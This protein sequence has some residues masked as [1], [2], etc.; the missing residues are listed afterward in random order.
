MVDLDYFK[1]YNDFHGHV[2]GD[3]LL[4]RIGHLLRHSIG[5][6]DYMARYGGEEFVIL[7]H[8]H[9]QHDLENQA[10][11]LCQTV[12]SFPFMGKEAQPGQQLTISVGISTADSTGQNLHKL[13]AEADAALYSSKHNGRNRFTFYSS[14]QHKS[15]IKKA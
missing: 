6:K 7:C 1:N 12:A 15:K 3:Y 10:I 9:H 14:L 5:E 8:S 11:K 13:I 4:Q 2:M